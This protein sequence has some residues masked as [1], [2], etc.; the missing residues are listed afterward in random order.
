VS[1]G[2]LFVLKSMFKQM[3]YSDVADR[4]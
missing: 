1:D 2:F 3:G 4:L